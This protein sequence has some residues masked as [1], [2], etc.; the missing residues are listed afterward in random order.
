MAYNRP[1]PPTKPASAP[2]VSKPYQLVSFPQKAPV[3]NKPIG[4]DSYKTKRLSGKISLR[5]TVKTA[6]FIA[7]GVVA[8]GNDLS[9]RYRNIPLIKVSVGQ[10][11]KLIL[12][13]SSLKGVIRSI[14]EAITLS[15]LCKTRANREKIPNGYSECKTKSRNKFNLHNSTAVY[16]FN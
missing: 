5:L 8:M 13:G 10:G 3:R 9:N 11:E 1:S 15:C 2:N 6:S 4:Q 16:E 14:Y 7:S 12:P